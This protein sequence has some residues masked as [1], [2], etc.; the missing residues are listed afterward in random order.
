MLN[1]VRQAL[2]RMPSMFLEDGGAAA[3]QMLLLV[4]S[5]APALPPGCVSGMKANTQSIA[6]QLILVL[7]LFAA[8]LD[9]LQDCHMG[10]SINQ[11]VLRPTLPARKFEICGIVA[12]SER[13]SVSDQEEGLANS[14]GC[15]CAAAHDP[16]PRLCS[17]SQ[18]HAGLPHAAPWYEPN[19]MQLHFD[20]IHKERDDK[21]CELI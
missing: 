12:I 5:M 20:G 18:H 16:L 21:A 15:P 10:V 6:T 1:L 17:W 9:S 11:P 19:A 13:I 8:G 4:L 14:G 3:K 2:D 7:E